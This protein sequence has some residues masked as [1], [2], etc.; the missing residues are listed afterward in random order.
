MTLLPYT[1][2]LQE[3]L[4]S[5]AFEVLDALAIRFGPAHCELMWV[6][7]TPVLV[8]VGARL[9]AGS[10]AVLSRVCGGVCQL[11]ETVEAILAPDRFLATLNNQPRLQRRA[12]NVFLSPQRQGRLARRC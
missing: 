10:N 6:D 3:A 9:S 1:G 7:G 11:D 12:V 2:E 4:R 5:Y 8:E